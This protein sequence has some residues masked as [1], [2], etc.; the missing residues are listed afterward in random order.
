MRRI[1][2]ETEQQ[3]ALNDSRFVLNHSDA[4]ELS[5]SSDDSQL[6]FRFKDVDTKKKDEE[7]K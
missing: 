2:K 6:D 4:D 5:E 3:N 1:R 7:Q